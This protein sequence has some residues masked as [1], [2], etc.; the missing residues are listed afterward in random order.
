MTGPGGGSDKLPTAATGPGAWTV[1]PPSIP[2][3]VI[4]FSHPTYSGQ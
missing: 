3:F 4:R 2:T 1:P